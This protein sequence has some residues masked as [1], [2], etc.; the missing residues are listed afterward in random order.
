MSW[1][2]ANLF[3]GVFI[4]VMLSLLLVWWIARED[5]K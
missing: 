1:C 4:G 5:M 2:V 3:I